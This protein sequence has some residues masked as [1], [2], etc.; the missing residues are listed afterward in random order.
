MWLKQVELWKQDQRWQAGIRSCRH[1]VESGFYSQCNQ[2][3]LKGFE[4][5]FTFLQG[6]SNCWV[7]IVLQVGR[8]GVQG[9]GSR[10]DGRR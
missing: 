8:V 4:Q 2:K 6:C 1:L 9:K 7:R 5:G 3:P 10:R